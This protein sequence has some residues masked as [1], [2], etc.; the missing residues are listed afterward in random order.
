MD[1][2]YLT[3]FDDSGS[4]TFERYC[5]QAHIAFPYCLDCAVGG[6]VIC[7][8]PEHLE[9]IAIEMSDGWRFLQVKTRDLEKGPWKLSHLTGKGGGLRSLLRTHRL[10]SGCSAIL[11]LHLEGA[12][13][14]KDPI[15]EL[16]SD[17]G[18]CSPA[19]VDRIS[20]AMG[21]DVEECRVFLQ[22][23]R[24]VR[25]HPDRG[26]I[27][28]QNMRILVNQAPHLAAATLD[29]IYERT[30]SLIYAA[31]QARLL[32]P[33]WKR[34]S[35]LR[36][37]LK[38]ECQRRFTQKQLTREHFKLIVEALRSLPRPLLMRMV[39]GSSQPISVLEQKLIV[40]GASQDP[41]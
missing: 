3:D 22:G 12:I 32:P 16:T 27:Q 21:L 36:Q 5:Y 14:R 10:L 15:Q 1:P 9:D 18:R 25:S 19:I 17:R 34:L 13:S 7:V 24:L 29:E 31:M 30:V 23:V 41:Q 11:E 35:V 40:G 37:S 6:D 28:A 33:R 4:R 2:T 26:T 39:S 20:E 8:V 38:G